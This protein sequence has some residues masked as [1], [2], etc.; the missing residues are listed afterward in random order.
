MFISKN[1]KP[2]NFPKK[3]KIPDLI[4]HSEK[5]VRKRTIYF[6]FDEIINE[7]KVDLIRFCHHFKF[8]KVS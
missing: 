4:Y 7:N 8:Y 6:I 5:F 3:R 2:Y 1:Y